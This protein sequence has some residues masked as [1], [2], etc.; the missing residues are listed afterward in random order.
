MFELFYLLIAAFRLPDF[1]YVFSCELSFSLFF[2]KYT[3][4]NKHKI[5]TPILPSNK[6]FSSFV[7]GY[8][9]EPDSGA[10]TLS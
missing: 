6:D 2:K 7:F 3:K 1:Y 8:I 4:K 10:I 9:L 5:N